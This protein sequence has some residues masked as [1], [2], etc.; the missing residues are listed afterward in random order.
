M[1]QSTDQECRT[2]WSPWRNSTWCVGIGL[3]F[4]FVIGFGI[5]IAIGG[6]IC[7]GIGG[8]IGGGLGGVNGDGASIKIGID[9][10][11]GPVGYRD[12]DRVNDS[13]DR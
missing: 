2:L 1:E 5:G 7:S 8:G 4:G 9:L 6:C 13:A 12:S 11:D 3:G 10:Y